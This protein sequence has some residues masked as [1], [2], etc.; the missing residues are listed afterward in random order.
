MIEFEDLLSEAAPEIG[1]VSSALDEIF[2]AEHRLIAGRTLPAP[3]RA[4]FLLACAGL[5]VRHNVNGE[6]AIDL[7]PLALGVELL[8]EAV[9]DHYERLVPRSEGDPSLAVL[10]GDRIYALG[11][12]RISSYGRGDLIGIASDTVADISALEAS[13]GAEG[14]DQ[15][16]RR[17]A[18]EERIFTAALDMA[19]A[20]ANIPSAYRGSLE[21]LG[22]EG[23]RLVA[24]GEPVFV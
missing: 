18:R 19:C 17:V 16:A 24:A 9:R 6:P 15:L 21:E 11:M 23:A 1:R 2:A 12:E 7:L 13:N 14:K 22:H 4:A 8:A 20:A 3:E 5:G 10:G